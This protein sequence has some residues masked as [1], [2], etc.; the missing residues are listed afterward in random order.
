MNRRGVTL[1]ELMIALVISAALVGAIYRTFLTQQNTYAVQDDVSD[2]QQNVRVAVNEMM[3]EIRMAGF[4]NIG[5]ILPVTINGTV[6]GNVI[7][8]DVP[9]AGAL[10]IL[11]IDDSESLTGIN[12]PTQITVNNIKHGTKTLFDTGDRKYISIAG[13]ETYIITDIAGIAAPYTLT[14]DRAVAASYITDGTVSVFPIRAIT[15]IVPSGT[16]VLRRNGNLG[17]GNQPLADNIENVTFQYLDVNGVQTANPP[18]FRTVRV[19][20]TARTENTDPKYKSG[21]GD[22]YRRRQV[23]SNILL[24]NMGH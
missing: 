13:S 2:M 17:G 18:D 21:Q 9:S 7:N 1:I 14:L 12:P 10:T 5:A 16:F 24:R 20:L 3:R 4:G 19:S 23:T 8:P 11:G 6:Y 15:F 22:G